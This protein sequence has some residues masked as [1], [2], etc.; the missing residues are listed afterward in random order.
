MIARFDLP[1]GYH[2]KVPFERVLV[3][4]IGLKDIC[5]CYTQVYQSNFADGLSEKS[6][7]SVVWNAFARKTD[8]STGLA[9]TKHDVSI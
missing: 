7:A 2:G 5:D 4:A 1:I 6:I 8:D 3:V 9:Y